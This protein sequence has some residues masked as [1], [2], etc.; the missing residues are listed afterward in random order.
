[1]SP[2]GNAGSAG[3]QGAIANVKVDG[4]ARSRR[5]ESER[6]KCP[7]RSLLS[8][9]SERIIVEVMRDEP[10]GHGWWPAVVLAALVAVTATVGVLIAVLQ[11]PPIHAPTRPTTI[12]TLDAPTGPTTIPTLD[13]S[14]AW[15]GLCSGTYNGGCTLTLTQTGDAL[16]GMFLLPSPS[17]K[18]LNVRGNL[19]GSAITLRSASGVA[20]TGTLSGATLSGVYISNG[21]TYS[22]SVTLSP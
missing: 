22:W 19:I 5:N 2:D 14:G 6:T 11:R 20:F 13:L 9:P 18:P 3:A 4:R 10:S 1:M 12:P 17:G 7:A 15:G 8:R 16:D 21:K